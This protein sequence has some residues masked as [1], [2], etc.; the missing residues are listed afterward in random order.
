MGANINPKFLF[1]MSFFT[2]SGCLSISIPSFSRTS[3][4]PHFEVRPLFPCLATFTPRLAKTRE[5]VVDILSV[6][7][8]SPPVPH[9]SKASVFKLTFKDF[10]LSTLAPP[11]ISS[12]ASPLSANLISMEAIFSS[13]R[14]PLIIRRNTNCV[15]SIF[16]FILFDIFSI[17]WSMFILAF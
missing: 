9:I 15:S 12:E 14:S 3:A 5:A 1:S 6:C 2:S 17:S 16:K 4:E 11:V 10:S 8:P 7:F 13:L